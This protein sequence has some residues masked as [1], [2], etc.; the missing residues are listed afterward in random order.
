VLAERP[1]VSAA[2]RQDGCRV[3]LALAACRLGDLTCPALETR[4]EP[5]TLE[6]ILEI[7]VDDPAMSL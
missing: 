3:P 6:V 5:P 7:D 4:P 1:G 2:E